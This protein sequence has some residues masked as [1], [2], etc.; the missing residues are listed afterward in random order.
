MSITIQPHY[1]NAQVVSMIQH[2]IDQPYTEELRKTVE[3][4]TLRSARAFGPGHLGTKD[5]RE[6]RV[7]L[8]VDDAQV[9]VN[10]QFG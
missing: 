10:I 1:T 8:V 6:E 3:R 9:I 4:E 7:N 2:V 5:Y